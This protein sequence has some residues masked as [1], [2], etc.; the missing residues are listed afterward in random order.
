MKCGVLSA[1]Y[2]GTLKGLN[3][4]KGTCCKVAPVY[5]WAWIML[6][7]IF[8]QNGPS[9]KHLNHTLFKNKTRILMIYF[10]KNQS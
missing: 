1:I 7:R 9:G 2:V 5:N 10:A 3:Y 6:L 4:L 8:P